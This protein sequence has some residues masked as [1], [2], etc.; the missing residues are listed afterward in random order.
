VQSYLRTD[1]RRCLGGDPIRH[2]VVMTSEPGTPDVPAL[3]PEVL[4]TQAV[5]AKKNGEVI[6]ALWGETGMY[7]GDLKR[8]V[9]MTDASLS[10]CLSTLESAGIVRVS[11]HLPPGG[12]RGVSVMY[13]IDTE[14]FD[15]VLNGFTSWIKSNHTP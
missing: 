15:E 14:R 12:R 11:T 7:F 9:D 6:R 1:T 4:L 5:L 2:D 3:P 8:S 13:S 10:R